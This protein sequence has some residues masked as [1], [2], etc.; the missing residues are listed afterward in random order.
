MELRTCLTYAS[1]L[2]LKKTYASIPSRR[3]EHNKSQILTACNNYHKVQDSYSWKN[4]VHRFGHAAAWF[5]KNNDNPSCWFYNS[6]TSLTETQHIY[7][8]IYLFIYIWPWNPVQ[9]TQN[10]YRIRTPRHTNP[11]LVKICS[12]MQQMRNEGLHC[13]HSKAGT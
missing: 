3:S 1:L 13:D 12:P 6:T 9:N 8:Y 4:G 2:P 5:S 7:I 10:I 11:P